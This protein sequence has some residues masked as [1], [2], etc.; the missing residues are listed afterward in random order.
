MKKVILLLFIALCSLGVRAEDIK[1]GD[2]K[3]KI[4]PNGTAEL[5]DYKKAFGDIVI[6]ETV[7]HPK[8][9]KAY[10]VTQIAQNAFKGSLVTSV[11]VPS[12]V[13]YI[14]RSAF[15][16]CTLL[17]SV[18]LPASVTD[19]P[20]ECFYGCLN[21]KEL[22]GDLSNIENVGPN[23]FYLAALGSVEPTIRYYIGDNKVST[24]YGVFPEGESAP[25]SVPLVI[26]SGINMENVNV[27]Q[28]TGTPPV[29]VFQ[30]KEAGKQAMDVMEKLIEVTVPRVPNVYNAWWN[31]STYLN[32]GGNDEKSL[33]KYMLHTSYRGMEPKCY[34]YFGLETT[35]EG[36]KVSQETPYGAYEAIEVANEN[37]KKEKFIAKLTD[38]VEAAINEPVRLPNCYSNITPEEGVKYNSYMRKTVYILCDSVYMHKPEFTPEEKRSLDGFINNCLMFIGGDY[39]IPNM[40]L[41]KWAKADIL[42][43]DADTPQHKE[44]YERLLKLTERLLQISGNKL[45]PYHHAMQLAAL[46]GLGRWN[47]ASAYFPKVHRSVTENGIYAVPYELTYIQNEIKKRG[48]KAITPS[49][50][51][52][53]SV[54]KQGKQGNNTDLIEFFAGKAVEAGVRHYE[55]KRAEKKARE[56]F[57]QSVGLDKKGRPKK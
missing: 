24:T 33:G 57:Y 32:G 5:K 31:I 8:T 52:G 18:E 23:A 20:Q 55:K 35:D 50:K 1:I 48:Y 38:F 15:K 56:M 44:D 14:G 3:Y 53:K 26:P 16:E 13:S 49:Y 39:G 30:D 42:N 45:D 37:W 41:E 9:G 25:T 6:P 27:L 34:I 47:E 54:S 21:L 28:F 22:N 51:K 4:Q 10:P 46:C 2:A 19:I 11:K 36:M 12:S 17:V 29:L 43:R 7:T 40:T